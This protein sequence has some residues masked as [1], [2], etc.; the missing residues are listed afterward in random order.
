MAQYPVG[1]AGKEFLEIFYF[2]F[3]GTGSGNS[4]GNPA[5]LVTKD[6]MDIPPGLLVR[7]VWVIVDVAVTGTTAVDIGDDDDPDGFVPAAS[8]T[9]ATPAV[10]GVSPDKR[11]VYLQD[12]GMAGDQMPRWKYYTAASTGKEI[13]AAFTTANTAGALRV[14]VQGLY[15]GR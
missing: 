7:D 15:L 1:P 11:G 3:G 8:I 14:F 10:Y 6:L 2:A 5:P 13:K 4:S 9:L 12:G